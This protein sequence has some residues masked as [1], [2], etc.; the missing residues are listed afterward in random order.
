VFRAIVRRA[1]SRYAGITLGS[2]TA[3]LKRRPK[4][5]VVDGAL[6]HIASHLATTPT[7]EQLAREVELLLLRKASKDGM[8]RAK[9]LKVLSPKAKLY[10]VDEK[11]LSHFVRRFNSIFANDC[12]RVLFVKKS[13]GAKFA[14]KVKRVKSRVLRIKQFGQERF[15]AHPPTAGPCRSACFT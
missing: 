1:T 12:N 2:F 15:N 6:V 7:E 11:G 13:S 8:T 3:F 14:Q 9:L 4:F 10:L 5:A